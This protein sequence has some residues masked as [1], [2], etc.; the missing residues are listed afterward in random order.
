MSF[1]YDTLYDLCKDFYNKM[2]HG[3]GLILTYKDNECKRI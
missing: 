3:E 2:S 1:S